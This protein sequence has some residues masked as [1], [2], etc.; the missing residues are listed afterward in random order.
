MTNSM[1][2][3][4]KNKM[5]RVIKRKATSG[6]HIKKAAYGSKAIKFMRP[7]FEFSYFLSSGSCSKLNRPME[8]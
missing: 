4:V 7:N 5:V 3:S 2:R 8:F 1:L 6:K